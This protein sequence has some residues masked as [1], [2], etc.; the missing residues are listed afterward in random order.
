MRRMARLFEGMSPPPID[1]GPAATLL[2]R[3]TGRVFDAMDERADRLQS[4]RGAMGDLA[5]TDGQVRPALDMDPTFNAVLME[6]HEAHGKLARAEHKLVSLPPNQPFEAPDLLA[7]RDALP[8]HVLARP[9]LA[10]IL[11]V[12]PPEPTE[13]IENPLPPLPRA[14]TFEELDEVIAE[15]KRR[16]DLT[17]QKLAA[18]SEAFAKQEPKKLPRPAPP[19]FAKEIPEAQSEADFVRARARDHFEEISMIG[20][21]RAPLLGDPWRVALTLERRMMNAID[22]IA[23][24]GSVGIAHLEALVLDSPAK[25]PSRAFGIGVALG[26]IAGRD[27]LAAAER[28]AWVLRQNDPESLSQL[29]D[30]LKIVPHGSVHL[31]M[32]TLLADRDPAMRALAIDVLAY[33]GMATPDEIARAAMDAPAV[34]AKALPHAAIA[35]SPT[36]NDGIAQALASGDP[37][38]TR[39]AWLAMALAGHPQTSA[40]LGAAL[41]GEDQEIAALLLAISG[42]ARDADDLLR[43]ANAKPSRPLITA[44]GWAGAADAIAPLMNFLESSDDVIKLAAAYA[45]ERI[46]G[47]GLFEENQVPVEE[48]VVPEPPDPDIGEPKPMN[49]AKQVSDPR[50]LPAEPSPE[51]VEQPTTNVERWRAWWAEQGPM[52]KSGLRYRR[53]FPYTPLVSL[54][55]L[56]TGKCT[57]GERRTLTR[58]LFIR[59]GQ[60][61]R[62]DPID[63]VATQE[64]ALREWLPIAQR[65]STKPGQWTRPYRGS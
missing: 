44:I 60:H 10:P 16:A 29:G 47:A 26:C 50:D 57:P 65:A 21:S 51:T 59:T 6:I 5:A 17:S 24:M 31:A 15:M 35:K 48:I 58:E 64:E 43:A 41:S 28:A 46:T 3:A 54:Q 42:D 12:Q 33:R 27:A 34:A 14:K 62:M 37:A 4:V 40:A 63:F 45:L 11:R 32:K 23:S 36:L 19:G 7:S 56:D 49:L 1:L 52:F 13:V 22:A 9:S 38:A 20:S 39:G 55:E 30:A 53:G 2:A 25:D 18:R 61:V 8:L